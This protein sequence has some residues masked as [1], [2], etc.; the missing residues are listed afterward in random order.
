MIIVIFLGKII[1]SAIKCN[2]MITDY[3]YSSIF[4]W[5]IF[6]MLCMKLSYD[7]GVRG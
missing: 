7:A 5:F 4:C 2:G 1:S 6:V 3:D